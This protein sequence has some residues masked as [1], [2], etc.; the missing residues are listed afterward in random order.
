MDNGVVHGLATTM[1]NVDVPFEM[2]APHD[3]PWPPWPRSQYNGDGQNAEL[4]A[5]DSSGISEAGHDP[6]PDAI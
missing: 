5:Y 4:A 3:Q 2:D 6:L 1:A